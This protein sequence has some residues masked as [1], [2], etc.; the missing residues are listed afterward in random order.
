MNLREESNTESN[1]IKLL[2]KGE[3]FQILDEHKQDKSNQWY[4]IKTKSG[5]TGWFCGIYNGKAM[6][7]RIRN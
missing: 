2:R 5:L 4:F 7:E 6:F 3:E 1:I